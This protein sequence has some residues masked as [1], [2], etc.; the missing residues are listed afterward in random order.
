MLALKSFSAK[1]AKP[2]AS[3]RGT[4]QSGNSMKYLR[5]ASDTYI[6]SISFLLQ[7]SS[8]PISIIY[9]SVLTTHRIP[10]S[11]ANVPCINFFHCHLVRGK[12]VAFDKQRQIWQH[13]VKHDGRWRK[14]KVP[15]VIQLEMSS[16][17]IQVLLRVKGEPKLPSSSVH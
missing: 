17:K 8:L 12:C 13:K 16:A 6:S 15:A 3:F 2:L 14:V 1:R 7:V 9:Q 4:I 11:Q 10:L 5:N